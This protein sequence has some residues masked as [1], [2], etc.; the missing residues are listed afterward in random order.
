GIGEDGISPDRE[1]A[2]VRAIR[3][4]NSDEKS[5]SV[6]PFEHSRRLCAA[7]DRRLHQVSEN[8]S[9]INGGAINTNGNSDRPDN[10]F[11][12]SAVNR[13]ASGDGSCI[14]R[15]DPQSP[16]QNNQAALAESQLSSLNPSS[17]PSCLRASVPSCLELH[18]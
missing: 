11:A 5:S 14:A 13:S 8:G 16:E 4:H 18:N 15:T 17:L 2:G 6:Y 7:D 3:S 10:G 12:E 1:D 9:R